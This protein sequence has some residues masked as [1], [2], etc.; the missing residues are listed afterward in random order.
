MARFVDRQREFE[1]LDQVLRE[2]GAHFV[3]VYGRRRVGK[4]TLLLNWVQQTGAPYL[5]WVARRET[6]DAARH[7]LARAL[8]RWAY[9][10]FDPEP[11]RFDS[12]RPVRADVARWP[13]T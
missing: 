7:S 10:C 12:W 8:W 1:E 9:P 11:P 4:T 2:P 6:A 13:K 5:Y 3:V